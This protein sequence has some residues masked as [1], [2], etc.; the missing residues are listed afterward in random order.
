MEEEI[1]NE[2]WKDIIQVKCGFRPT[3]INLYSFLQLLK[4]IHKTDNLWTPK[5]SL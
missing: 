3:Q 2:I 5:K 1:Q 4:G